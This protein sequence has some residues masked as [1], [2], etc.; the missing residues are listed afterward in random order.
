M[1]YLGQAVYIS[2]CIRPHLTFA[3]N[4]LTQ[5]KPAEDDDPDIERMKENKYELRYGNA[6]L[7]TAETQVFSYASFA[8]NKD[9]SPRL[10]IWSR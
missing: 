6:D 8:H 4:Q 10:V 5:T 7:G 3:V 1:S 9:L 2:N